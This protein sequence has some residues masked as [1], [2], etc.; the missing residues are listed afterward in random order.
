MFNHQSFYANV[1]ADDRVI[2]TIFDLEDET[3]WK[4]MSSKLITEI[5]KVPRASLM[6]STVD[7]YEEQKTLEKVLKEKIVGFRANEAQANTTW[8]SQLGYL[9][10]QCLLSYELQKLSNQKF[11]EDEFRN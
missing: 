11:S 1:Q 7:V 6:R 4:A 2:S 9:L 8:D 5:P 10:N 3:L